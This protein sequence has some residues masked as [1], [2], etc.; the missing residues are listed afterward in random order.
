M[1]EA[2]SQYLLPQ[3]STPGLNIELFAG[4]GGVSSGA[5]MSNMLFDIAINHNPIALAIH[6]ANFP[7]CIQ[8]VND[9]FE[10]N[11]SLI[12][13]GLPVY[14]VH[15]SPDCTFHSRAK[16]KALGRHTV[17]GDDCATDHTKLTIN[18]IERVRGL[19]WILIAWSLSAR[20]KRIT[21]E[22]VSE[23][24][25]WG[26]TKVDKRGNIIP[27][28]SKRGQ[29]FEAFKGIL[30]TGIRKNHPALKEV[31]KFLK[32]LL[33]DDYNE[34]ALIKG[35]GYDVE[36]K[37]LTA[38]DYGAP[39][40][41]KRLFMI[42]R[43]DGVKIKWPK[44]THGDPKKEK[45]KRG[46]LLPWKTAGECIDWTIPA[47][48]IFK[49]KKEIKEELG[50]NTV[51]PLALN[52]MRRI[53]KGIRKFVLDSDTPYIVE[54]TRPYFQTYYGETNG[55][56]RGNRVDRPIHTITA[57]GQRHGLVVP[58]VVNLKGTDSKRMPIGNS[59]SDP[60]TTIT[61]SDSHGIIAAHLLKFYGAEKDG[62]DLAKPIHTITT[63]ERFSLIEE[64]LKKE[65]LSEEERYSAWWIARM[66]EEFGEESTEVIGG[67]E[68][69]RKRYMLTR[70]GYVIVDIG[71]R[72]LS[73]SELFLAQGFP[74]D[75]VYNPEI[76]VMSRGKMIKRR[77]T[78][79]EAVR[80]VGNSVPPHFAK[81]IF[82]ALNEEEK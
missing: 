73:V 21:L 75:F 30:S 28:L 32:P 11:P 63:K 61:T 9:V 36:F 64:S 14:T 7:H 20:P 62:E 18:D 43:C 4:G 6:K 50:V 56:T 2:L 15:G 16:G 80:M 12:T 31:R 51:R 52:T 44:V 82:E 67:I 23:F 25:Q 46:E 41:R 72:M 59:P 48:S 1:S 49:S 35:L 27:D 65:P 60:L 71:M 39:T 22:N 54:N 40:S 58:Y 42:A 79:T 70:D 29:T 3:N 8:M 38:S 76:E 57:G 33:G 34:E 55:E 68:L 78:K 66:M 17:C 81:A 26:P 77:V 13:R 19:A 10:Y 53:A 5:A 74:K 37:E 69:P 47:P 24:M 45:V